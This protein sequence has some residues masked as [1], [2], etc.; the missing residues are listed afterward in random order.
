M[1]SEVEGAISS[2]ERVISR[3]PSVMVAYSGGVDSSLLAYLANRCTRTLAVISDS[4]SLPRKGLSDAIT[5]A[6]RHH[7][8]YRVIH[9]EEY[10][11]EEYLSNPPERCYYCKKA[12]YGAMETLRK[13]LG[14]EVIMDGTNIDDLKDIRPGIKA[15]GEMGIIFPYVEAGVNKQ[16]I[17]EMARH[18][19]L[20]IWDKPS[21]PCLSSRIPAGRRITPDALS[22]VEK[23]ENI[24]RDAGFRVVRVRDY[25][26]EA[27]VELIPV[28]IERVRGVVH[29]LKSL[30]YEKVLVSRRGYVPPG[31]RENATEEFDEL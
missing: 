27:R 11:N 12:T 26:P 23:A 7:I 2:V 19:N 21:S 3:Y 18:L 9:S 29:I 5:F 6:R 28:D 17:R 10:L 31:E 24:L 22:R 30:G 13:A 4:P 1:V 15:A 25:Y 14:Y 8:K 16:M 20:S